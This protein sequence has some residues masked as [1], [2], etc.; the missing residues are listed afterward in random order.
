MVVEVPAHFRYQEAG[1]LTRISSPA[2][3]VPAVDRV[4]GSAGRADGDVEGRPGSAHLEVHLV[5]PRGVS[6]LGGAAVPLVNVGVTT[7]AEPEVFV[8]SLWAATSR[9]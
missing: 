1:S 8:P 5:I 2:V 7:G 6:E 3:G 9:T 4:G